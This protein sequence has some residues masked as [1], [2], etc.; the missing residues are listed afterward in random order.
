MSIIRYSSAKKYVEGFSEQF[1]NCLR[2]YVAIGKHIAPSIDLGDKMAFTFPF[3]Y[4]TLFAG[5][6]NHF[7]TT[8]YKGCALSSY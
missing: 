7:H 5:H 4:G 2:R 1:F 8:K 3:L 6:G